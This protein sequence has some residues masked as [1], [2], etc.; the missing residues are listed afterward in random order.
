MA[1]MHGDKPVGTWMS[2]VW[3]RRRD[4]P[5]Y[6]EGFVQCALG[7]LAK[8]YPGASRRYPPLPAIKDAL[9]LGRSR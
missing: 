1:L 5:A 8:N 7:C 4:L 2:L 9:I 6:A 3:N